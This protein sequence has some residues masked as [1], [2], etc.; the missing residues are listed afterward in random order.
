VSR[1]VGQVVIVGRDAAA[2]LT[3]L[4]LRRAFGRTGV[5]V[6][7]VELPSLL[8]EVDVYAALP[9]LG[10]LHTLLGLK[11]GDVLAGSAGLPVLAQRFANWSRG[12]APFMHGYDTERP[13]IRDID[14]LQFWVKARGEGLKVEMDDFSIAAAAA[15]QG[16]TPIE[17]DG[18]S[19]S[20]T[21]ASGYHLDARA[22][23]EVVR[24]AALRSGVTAT[25]DRISNVEREDSRIASVTLESGRRVTGDLFI[26]ASG[27]EAALIGGQPDAAFKPW[28]DG[29]STDRILVASGPALDPLPA[30][31]QIAAF[32]AGWLGLYP[33]K[34]RTAVVAVY[35]SAIQ[36][37]REVLQAIPVLSGLAIEGDVTVAPLNAGAR[38]AWRGNCVAVGEAAVVLE[39][40]DAVPLHLIH[41]GISHLI[42]LFPVDAD[43]IPEADAFNRGFASH[44]R[45]VRDFQRAH[46]RLNQRYDEPFWDAARDGAISSTLRSR[47]DLFGAR[48][49][50]AQIEDDSFQDQNWASIFI[51]HGLIPRTYDPRVDAVPATEQMDKVRALL[52]VVA[53]EVRS[54]PDLNARFGAVVTPGVV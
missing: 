51:G 41:L 26:D 25:S 21:V 5:A 50:M 20:R 24:R 18:A 46:Y 27:I 53:E 11:A 44:V 49:G 32:G 47:L 13:A 29:V 45:S 33:L 28:D 37:D 42:A 39:P 10:A 3:A 54:M 9:S 31:S 12:R 35:D 8:D 14:F 36:S 15:K 16:R 7:V 6:T 23:V 2:W 52:A 43:T 34:G 1:G 4:A 19:A 30:F 38:P 48:G 17:P 40:L 22:Y